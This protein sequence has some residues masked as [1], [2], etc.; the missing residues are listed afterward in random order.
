MTGI[1]QAGPEHKEALL[2][3]LQKAPVENTFL[4]ADIEQY[5][6]TAPFQQ[7]WA[8]WRGGLPAAVYLRFYQNLLIYSG[9]GGIDTAFVERIA[10]EYG[11]MV[12]M[13]R[14]ADMETVLAWGASSGWR[15]QHKKLLSLG[16]APS[17]AGPAGGLRKAGPCDADAI[18]AF[19]QQIEGFAAMYASK[20]MLV[21]RLD[22]DDGIHLVLEAGGHILAHA[23]S[24]VA[25]RQTV[26]LGGVATRADMRGRGFASAVVSE[27]CRR[28][29]AKGLQPCVYSNAQPGHDL[30]LRLGF[31]CRG[32]WD[33]LERRP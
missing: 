29:Q 9:G 16:H 31:T 2:H 18:Y 22:S 3:F 21:Q 11:I 12:I 10:R 4:L 33:T 24:T 15:A 1:F 20:E 5:G 13:G 14:G 6:F 25:T 23:N 19:L 28:M 17:L 30:F 26:V 8:M 27:L 32:T 7:V